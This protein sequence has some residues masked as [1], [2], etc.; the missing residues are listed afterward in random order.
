MLGDERPQPREAEHLALGVM[1]LY[2][3]VGVEEGRLAAFQDYLLLLITHTG[4][5]PQGHA[6]SPQF[7]CAALSAQV[8][9]VVASVGVE[10]STAF[11]LEDGIEAGY[12]HVERDIRVKYLVGFRQRLSGHDTPSLGDG[13]KNASR[14][15][16]HQ[17]CRH[18]LAGGIP[19]YDP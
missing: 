7:V 14:A 2:Q 5:K 4:H 15:G 11:W 6:P 12:E 18:A 1:G 9:Q 8:G 13:P 16:H 19:H 3:P 10:E 17:G